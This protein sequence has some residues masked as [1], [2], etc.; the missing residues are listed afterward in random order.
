M[1]KLMTRI[2]G[3]LLAVAL[4]GW[5]GFAIY[6]KVTEAREAPARRDGA[7]AVAVQTATVQRGP[8]LDQRTFTGTLNA[9]HQFA[10]APKIAGRIN[11]LHV[12]IGD[13]V[14]RNQVVAELDNAEFVQQV[15]EARAELAVGEASLEETRSN[16]ASAEREL[17]RMQSLREQRVASESELDKAQS[18]FDAQRARLRVAEAQVAQREAALRSAEVRLSYTQVR[19]SWQDD[20]TQRVVGERFADEGDTLAAN[21]PLVSV[22]NIATLRAVVFV[23][24]LDYPRMAMGQQA[25]VRA[26][27]FPDAVFEAEVMALSPQFREASRQARVELAVPNADGRLKPGMFVRVRLKLDE[28]AE[29]TI[30]PL[31][32]L[33]TRQNQQGVFVADV[34]A[35]TAR[36]L[37]VRVGITEGQRVQLLEPA[38]L[39]GRVVTLG[40][41]L[42][43]DGSTITLVDEE[44]PLITPASEDRRDEERDEGNDK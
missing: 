37:P 1:S 33:V 5:L 9:R 2:A 23:T 27:A 7:P 43:E 24:E 35:R 12:D 4:L 26:D 38:S 31:D 28:I 10:V 11:R 21:A 17:G 44:E 3:A 16:L 39:E 18:A 42:L 32:A 6:G 34:E 20:D 29:A 8:I 14:T 40:Q 13:V 36:F 30:V 25:Q 22:L 15:E 41:H 19:A